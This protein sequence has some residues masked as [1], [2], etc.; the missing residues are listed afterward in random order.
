MRRGA[1]HILVVDDDEDTSD[2]VMATLE[3]AGYDVAAVHSGAEAIAYLARV[4][5]RC[6]VLLDL[7]MVDMNGWEV[8]SALRAANRADHRVV[9]MS[10]VPD[11]QMP[12]GLPMLR[13]PF[14][15]EE[16]LGVV[17]ARCQA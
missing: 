13:K 16:L 11:D 9:V 2:V 5:D 12:R 1:H 10:G 14:T 3:R 7:L 15:S 6:V 17:R 8:I 4:P